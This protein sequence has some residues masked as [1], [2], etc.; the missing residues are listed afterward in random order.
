LGAAGLP[1]E[2]PDELAASAR[3]R[4][5]SH[6]SRPALSRTCS[7][8]PR[9]RSAVRRRRRRKRDKYARLSLP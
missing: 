4:S 7:A 6:P 1:G 3:S 9:S 5:T 8:A 2:R